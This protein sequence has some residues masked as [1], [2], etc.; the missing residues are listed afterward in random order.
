M[1]IITIATMKSRSKKHFQ[2]GIRICPFCNNLMIKFQSLM[3][4]Y[5][6][7][8]TFYKW[9]LAPFSL[10][11]TKKRVEQGLESREYLLPGWICA[12]SFQLCP[13]LWLYVLYITCQA[14][15]SKGFSRQEYRSGLPFPSPED[16]PEPGVEAASLIYSVLAGI[17][18]TT[19]TT[20]G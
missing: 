1:I 19:I 15:L 12:K 4:I 2:H 10:R 7:A 3:D 16:L 6:W 14:P 11:E 20:I 9:S 18:L 5:P 8:M 17:F 13:T